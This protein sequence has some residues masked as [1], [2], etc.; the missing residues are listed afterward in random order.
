MAP[1]N[2]LLILPVPFMAMV[3]AT[4]KSRGMIFPEFPESNTWKILFITIAAS[5]LKQTNVIIGFVRLDASNPLWEN[6]SDNLHHLRPGDLTLRKINP[7]AAPQTHN[8]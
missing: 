1:F 6:L 2:S 8:L 3:K 5:H 4:N 7:K